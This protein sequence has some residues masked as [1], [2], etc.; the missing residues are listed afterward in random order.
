MSLR[1]CLVINKLT[2]R[3]PEEG[4]GGFTGAPVGKGEHCWVSISG[5]GWVASDTLNVA[6]TSQYKNWLCDNILN[7]D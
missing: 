4:G 6:Q 7:Q 1:L 5:H 3:A 2:L